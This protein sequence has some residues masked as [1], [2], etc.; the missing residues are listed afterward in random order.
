[1]KT[2][3]LCLAL[4]LASCTGMDSGAQY[5]LVPAFPNLT[6]ERPLDIRTPNDGQNR[7][8]VVEQRG[9]ISWF[10]NDVNVA[11]LNSF[12]DIRDRVDDRRNEMGLLGLAFH[13]QYDSNGYFFVNYTTDN[14]RRTRIS[15]FTASDDDAGQVS[16]ESEKIIME[17]RQP[18]GNHN[19]GGIVFGPDGMLYIGFGDGGSGGDPNEDGQD[20]TTLLGSIARIDVDVEDSE[21]YAIPQDNPFVGTGNGVRE[22]IYAYGLRNPWRFSFDSSTGDLWAGDVGQNAY[23]EIDIVVAGGNYG[24]DEREGSHCFEPRTGCQEEGLID[25]VWEYPHERGNS[26]VTGGLVYHGNELSGL[27][28]KYIYA[29]F[30]SGRVWSLANAA[31]G[32]AIN[33]ELVRARFGISSFGIDSNRELYICGFDGKIYKLVES[34]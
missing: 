24:W 19:G 23:E 14:P 16:P 34:E 20:P 27:Q 25:P 30:S 11:T 18:F 12:L 13:P 22:E 31:S 33:E 6:F 8:F 28:G 7:L 15:R 3:S 29:D 21:P 1:M 4:I 5:R 2:L 17:V 9:T 10:E 26:S 32:D